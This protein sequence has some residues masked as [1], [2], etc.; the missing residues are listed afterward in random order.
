MILEFPSSFICQQLLQITSPPKLHSPLTDILIV[1]TVKPVLSGY[2][3]KDKTK[4]L[5][6]NGSLMKVESIAECIKQ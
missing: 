6:T 1:S 4:I 2:S 5:N 3:K